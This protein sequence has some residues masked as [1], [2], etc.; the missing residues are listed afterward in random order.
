MAKISP[1][2]LQQTDLVRIISDLMARVKALELQAGVRSVTFVADSTSTSST[3]LTRMAWTTFPRS[4]SSVTVDV[5][6]TLSGATSCEVAVRADGTQIGSR[7]VTGSGVVT[8]SGFLP[9]AW[10]FGARKVVDVQ[11]KV[12]SGSAAVAVVGGWHR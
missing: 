7:T 5:S 4:G 6:V 11:V 3:T 9:P 2:D 10:A 12:N 8:V 1:G